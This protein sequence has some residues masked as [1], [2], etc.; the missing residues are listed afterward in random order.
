MKRFEVTF[1]A[2]LEVDE[3]VLARGLDAEFKRDMYDLIN[4]EGVV[5]HL[6]FNLARGAELKQLD[7]WADMPEAKATIREFNC[8]DAFPVKP[9]KKRRRA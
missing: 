9:E 4:E 6:A 2:T 1:S 7:G 5:K 8:D 3:A